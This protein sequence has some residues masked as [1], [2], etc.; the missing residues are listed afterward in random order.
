ML[1]K[2][3]ILLEIPAE[4]LSQD[5]LIEL[6]VA[7]C[8]DDIEAF[9]HTSYADEMESM[10]SQMVIFR[11]NQLGVEGSASAR[12]SGMIFAPLADYPEYILSQLKSFRRIR[13]VK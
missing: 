7:Q 8:K 12:M 13:T 1:E 5:D 6:L 10:C 2:I 4:D 11:F 9:C 3:K